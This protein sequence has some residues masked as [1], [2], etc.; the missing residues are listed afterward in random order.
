MI[1]VGVDLHTRQQSVAMLDVGTGEI[2]EKK[3]DHAGNQVR[4][5]YSTRPKPVL[6]GIEATGSM[7]W[8]LT[9]SPTNWAK[10]DVPGDANRRPLRG[11]R[12]NSRNPDPMPHPSERGSHQ[13]N[14]PAYHDSAG[15]TLPPSTPM[16]TTG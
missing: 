6:V 16:H 10:R 9:S 4:D 13:L 8:F 15:S 12:V 14:C 3:R 5:F 1:I 11:A 2:I 7:H